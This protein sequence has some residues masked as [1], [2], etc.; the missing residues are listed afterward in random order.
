MLVKPGNKSP[1]HIPLKVSCQL[2]DLWNYCIWI[3]LVLQHIEALVEIAIV[4]L[5]WMIIQDTLGFSFFMIRPTHL[6]FFKKFMIRAE[7]E[8]DLKVKKVRSDNGS[9][10]KNCKIKEL[11]DEKGMKHE[12]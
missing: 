6:I 2:Q 11:C 12:F 9:E 5:L 8:F 1:I 7:N 4:L 10:F 3:Y